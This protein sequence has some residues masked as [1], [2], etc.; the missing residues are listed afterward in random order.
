MR[1]LRAAIHRR[2]RNKTPADRGDIDRDYCI[3]SDAVI[4][5]HRHQMA[6]PHDCQLSG[7]RR[8][9]DL[10]QPVCVLY[11]IPGRLNQ[12]MMSDV[13]TRCTECGNQTPRLFSNRPLH[14]GTRETLLI[15]GQCLQ[16]PGEQSSALCDW[17][18]SQAGGKITRTGRTICHSCIELCG[19]C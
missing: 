8:L 18:G 4:I 14:K 11:S 19:R 13:H 9:G 2:Q 5:F 3:A 17:C 1:F 12:A 10:E 16:A 7:S 6:Y 15:C